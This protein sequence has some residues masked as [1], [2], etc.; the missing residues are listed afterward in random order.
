MSIVKT[1]GA[2]I[3]YEVHGEGPAI[4]F[5]HGAGGNAASWWRQV[6][7]FARNHKVVV[8]DHRIFGR[9]TCALEDF[10]QSRYADDLFAI[11]DAEGI[12]RAVIVCQSMGGRTGLR[13]ALDAPERV[14]CL[15][16]SNTAGGID[17]ESFRSHSVTARKKFAGESFGVVALAQD[18]RNRHPDLYYLYTHINGLNAAVTPQV[19]ERMND[20]RASINES[21]LDGF[22]TPT[23]C[24]TSPHDVLFPPA[25]IREVAG[26]IPGA[27]LIE[28]P[29]A[30]HSPYF[31]MPDAFNETVAAFVNKQP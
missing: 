22:A 5:A 13:A 14:R 25:V 10:D 30:G 12:D 28:L 8:F 17:R 11:L 23:L 21:R 9:S 2:S 4:V 15:I 26:L 6:P 24:I 18:Y 1:N 19:R 20:P 27:E 16:L 7:Y 31:E 29:G 3:Y